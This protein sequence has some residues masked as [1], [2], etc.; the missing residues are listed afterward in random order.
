MNV[1]EVWERIVDE[2]GGAIMFI[3]ECGKRN[4]IT[5]PNRDRLLLNGRQYPRND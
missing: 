1:F 4:N 3:L 2:L 5:L